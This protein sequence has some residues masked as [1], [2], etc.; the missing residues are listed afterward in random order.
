LYSVLVTN[1]VG[2]ILSS[3]ATLTLNL[4]RTLL[5]VPETHVASGGSITIPVLLTANGTENA[6]SFSLNFITSRL[7]YV[8]TILANGA[9]ERCLSTRAKP[10][11][12]GLAWP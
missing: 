11:L 7:T 6:L 8:S 2:S 9:A 4:G 12:D 10:V 1:T 5:Q 3:N